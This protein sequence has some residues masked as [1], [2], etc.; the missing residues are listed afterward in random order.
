MFSQNNEE[1]IVHDFFRD[2]KIQVLSIGENDG[3]TLSNV[4]RVL[5]NGSGGVLVEPSEKVFNKLFH[6]YFDRGDV[7]MYRSAISDYVGMGK[8]YDS[9]EHLKN[10]D[11]SLLS[12]LERTEITKWMPTTKFDETYV[13][14][15][16]FRTLIN[17]SPIKEFDLISCDTEGNDLCI[18]KQMD[19]R[20]MKTR[21]LIIEFNGKDQDKFDE[22]VIPQGL[23][24]VHK[25]AEN[26]IY[27]KS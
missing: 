18:L 10:G 26:L 12:S 4:R 15:M 21:M 17:V 20:E 3:V 11:L 27:A 1:E 7:F 16:N 14:V 5:M 13:P 24:L 2:E 19:L 9:G 8:F 25:N 6:L 22:L 23:V